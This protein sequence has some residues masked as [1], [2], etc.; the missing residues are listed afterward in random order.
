MLRSGVVRRLPWI[1]IPL[2][3][4]VVLVILSRRG[5][6]PPHRT[7][8]PVTIPP[9][10]IEPAP[11][12][13]WVSPA[14]SD[15]NPGTRDRPWLTLQHAAAQ[16]KGTVFVTAGTY[17]GFVLRRSG[18]AARPLTFTGVGEATIIPA[19]GAHDVIRLEG[20]AH[21]VLANLSVEGASGS[22]A[23]GI[24]IS[25]GS[26]DVTITSSH[27]RA[28]QSFG[29]QLEASRSVTILNNEIAGNEVGL[30]LY[31][32]DDP[33]GIDDVRIEGNVIHDNDRLV[34]SDP[35]PDN[36]FGANAIILHKT[37][38]SVLIRRNEFYANRGTSHDY[39]TDG[40]AIEIWGA[41]NVRVEENVFHDNENVLETGTDGP[42]CSHLTFVRNVAWGEPRWGR[43][44]GLI[45]RCASDSLIANNT[46]DGLDWFA[47]ELSHAQSGFGASIEGLRIVNNII[48]ECRAY[49]IRT[50][51]PSSVQLD[52]NLFSLSRA[53]TAEDADALVD[54]VGRGSLERLASLQAETNWEQHSIEADPD[55]VDSAAHDY[56]LMADS[57][58][59]G[60]G[61]VLPGM[62]EVLSVDIGRFDYVPLP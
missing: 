43:A 23:A 14:G 16:A 2:V 7:L 17:Q 36:D 15:V 38:G 56:R 47:F 45:L 28:N 40:G 35:E 26:S 49:V 10:S 39:G 11:V 8:V 18:T 31:A 32:E 46:L 41:S 1:L 33:E 57:A 27:I 30:R 58:A 50:E 42:E 52:Y 29:I 61:V 62:S 48:F 5:G 59:I 13:N 60:R 24:R 37:V 9:A 19:E 12:A 22:Y 4:S 25:D 20:V 51:L 55:F 54:I 21:V 3:V 6:E 53:A 44:V 34:V